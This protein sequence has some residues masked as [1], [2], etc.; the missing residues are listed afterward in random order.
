MNEREAGSQRPLAVQ[1]WIRPDGLIIQ[2]V[3][4]E[5]GE[6]DGYHQALLRLP[7]NRS[8]SEADGAIWRTTLYRSAQ[9]LRKDY[10]TGGL[11]KCF[12]Q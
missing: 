3:V 2:D 5:I 11:T 8:Q 12:S 7:S 9:V 10:R 4:E 6:I 1:E